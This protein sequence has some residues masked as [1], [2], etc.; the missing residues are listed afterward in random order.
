MLG[1]KDVTDL[2]Y[3]NMCSQRIRSRYVSIHSNLG[4]ATS[5]QVI[6]RNAGIESTL[7]ETPCKYEWPCINVAV[8]EED[9]EKAMQTLHQGGIILEEV[10]EADFF[11]KICPQCHSESVRRDKRGY[12]WT[13]IAGMLLSLL[14]GHYIRLN[15]QWQCLAC[16]QTWESYVRP[17]L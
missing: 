8:S 10:S 16:G 9:H 11:T 1:T 6:L 17:K 7:V 12:P 14:S 4:D 13:T 2:I 3:I 5:A 15:R